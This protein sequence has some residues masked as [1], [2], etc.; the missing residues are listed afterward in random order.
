M[1]NYYTEV[2]FILPLTS[3]QLSFAINVLDCIQ[4][5]EI[6]LRKKQKTAK[7]RSYDSSVYSVA[8]RFAKSHNDYGAD[9]FTLGFSFSSIGDGLWISY[10]ENIDTESAALF[11]HLIL[12]HFDSN[13]HIA[14]SASHTCSRPLL[15]AFGGHAAF[16]TKKGVKWMSTNYWLNSQID[17]FQSSIQSKSI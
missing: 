10:E 8:K 12:K 9:Y 11:C 6:D 5:D 7:A 14:I 4:D 13:N 17:R 3:E 1:A 16:V 15:D 2:S